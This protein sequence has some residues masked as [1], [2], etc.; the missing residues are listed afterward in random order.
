MIINRTYEH[1]NLLSQRLVS[2]L[3]GLRTFQHPCTYIVTYTNYIER[4]SAS[5]FFRRRLSPVRHDASLNELYNLLWSSKPE[6]HL[7]E[8]NVLS[9]HCEGLLGILPSHQDGAIRLSERLRL[10]FS[11]PF[12]HP[13][14]IYIRGL[15]GK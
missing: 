5:A 8:G 6:I 4:H 1:Q 7:T 11:F 2:F 3:V 14:Y 9:F 15:S 12:I 10:T 13:T